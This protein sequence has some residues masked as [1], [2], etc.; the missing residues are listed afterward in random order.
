MC[1]KQ[2]SALRPETRDPDRVRVMV[3]QRRVAT[4]TARS[5]IELGIT[6]GGAWTETM[7]AAAQRMEASDKAVSKARGYLSRRMHSRRQLDLKLNRAGFE[8]A[9]RREALDRLDTAGLL[10]DRLF[11]ERLV[12]E[13]RGRRG[14]GPRLVRDKLRA[15]GVA[16]AVINEVL[17][18]EDCSQMNDASLAMD[19]AQRQLAGLARHPPEVQKRRLYGRMARR[20]YDAE[21]IREVVD[22]LI[23]EGSDG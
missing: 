5:V 21:V 14:A 10:N 15:A 20:G 1:E 4:L 12:E 23:G 19:Y 8:P 11:A 18:D 7:A 2:V 16:D 13:W 22:R 9:I 6:V 17:T 3:G